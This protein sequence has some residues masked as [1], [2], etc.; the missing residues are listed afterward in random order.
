MVATIVVIVL[1]AVVG[2][3]VL[4]YRNR[5][6]RG[7][8]V[9][10]HVVPSRAAGARARVERAAPSGSARAP[11]RPGRPVSASSDPSRR[12]NRPRRARRPST[13]D[14]LDPGDRPGEDR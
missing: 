4:A 3:S 8:R 11:T 2:I 12:P 13:D 6:E 7:H 9:G 1:I 10:H 14:G 5:A